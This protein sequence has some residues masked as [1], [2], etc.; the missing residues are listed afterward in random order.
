MDTREFANELLQA[1]SDA[2]LFDRVA[3]RSE[4]PVVGGRAFSEDDATV[5]LHFYYNSVSGTL[6]FA[7]IEDK[8]R[9]WGIDYDNRRG[10]HLHPLGNPTAHQP[11]SPM[12]IPDIVTMLCE[13]RM[14]SGRD[15]E[16]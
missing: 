5:F 3:L 8:Q 14:W 4:G 1:L 7:L 9:I 12:S 6:A 13:L 15:E 2:V 16:E 10:W 11:I